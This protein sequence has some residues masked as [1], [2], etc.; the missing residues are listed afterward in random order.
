[1]KPG[2]GSPPRSMDASIRYHSGIMARRKRSTGDLTAA[3]IGY[4]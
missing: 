3:G 2:F 4:P 1:M